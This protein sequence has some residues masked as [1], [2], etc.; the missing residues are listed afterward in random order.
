MLIGFLE[1]FILKVMT[2]I[3]QSCRR[4]SCD[5]EKIEG[6]FTSHLIEVEIDGIQGMAA[7]GV[8]IVLVSYYSGLEH[9]RTL[10]RA[11]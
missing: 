8:K 2:L 9:G 10:F 7:A 6:D 4:T 1:E 11:C 3:G 5:Y